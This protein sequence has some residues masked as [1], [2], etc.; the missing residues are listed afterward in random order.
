M[1]ECVCVCDTNEISVPRAQ[2]VVY[3]TC[4]VHAIENEHVVRQALSSVTD[5][6]LGHALPQWPRRGLPGAC[7]H[8]TCKTVVCVYMCVYVRVCFLHVCV[9]GVCRLIC[10]SL[11]SS[12]FVALAERLIRADPALDHTNGFFVA[13]F[14]RKGSDKDIDAA[15]AAAAPVNDDLDTGVAATASRVT[16][17]RKAV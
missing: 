10:C 2:R 11:N 13:L 6:T 1:C 16:G 14:V 9:L 7:P 5:F 4:S 15:D 3:S 17:K 8:G 12:V